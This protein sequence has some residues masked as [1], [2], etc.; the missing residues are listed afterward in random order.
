MKLYLALLF[1]LPGIA[2]AS[3]SSSEENHAKD[4]NEEYQSALARAQN[5]IT[6]ERTSSGRLLVCPFLELVRSHS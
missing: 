1:V 4:H 3:L 5:K 6:R 2:N